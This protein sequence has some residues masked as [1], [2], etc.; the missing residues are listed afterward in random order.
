MNTLTNEETEHQERWGDL[1]IIA[2]G[3]GLEPGSL[4]YM[5]AVCVHSH[6]TLLLV[7]REGGVSVTL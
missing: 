6:T 7:Q 1:P 3:S 5:L 4:G 2:L